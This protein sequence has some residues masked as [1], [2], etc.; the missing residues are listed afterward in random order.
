[1]HLNCELFRLQ[2]ILLGV[3]MLSLD[4]LQL[5]EAK[6]N[7]DSGEPQHPSPFF[8]HSIELDFGRNIRAGWYMIR[9]FRAGT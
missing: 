5:L 2:F 9:P 6:G 4:R 1:M 7:F 3:S 8:Y